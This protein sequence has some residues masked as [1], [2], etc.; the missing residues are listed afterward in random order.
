MAFYG[1]PVVEEKISD[2]ELLETLRAAGEPLHKYPLMAKI[3]LARCE[4]LGFDENPEQRLIGFFEFHGH[5]DM[6]F[7][8]LFLKMVDEQ[9]MQLT[10]NRRIA[11]PDYKEGVA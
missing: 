11:L 9:K 3:F 10:S 8:C 2:T 1:N 4:A 6:S 7:R 5:T